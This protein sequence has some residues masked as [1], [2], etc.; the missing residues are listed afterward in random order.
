MARFGFLGGIASL[1]TAACCVLPITFMLLGAGGAWVA[2][3]ASAAALSPYVIAISAVVLATAWF[4]SLRGSAPRR[5]YALLG[6]GS[7]LT[8][9]AWIVLLNEEAMNDYLI[10]W[11]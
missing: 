2:V 4:L 3:L 7:L 8:A 11:M 6:G 1:A 9:L 10:Q 5:T